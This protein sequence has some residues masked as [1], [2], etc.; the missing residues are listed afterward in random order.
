MLAELGPLLRPMALTVF[1]VQIQALAVDLAQAEMS[2]QLLV[3]EDL[4]A[5][6]TLMVVLVDQEL[7]AKDLLVDL[8]TITRHLETLLVE[9]VVVV[10]LVVLAETLLIHEVAMLVT[11]KQ[12]L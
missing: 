10:V 7:P 3:A 6:A 2:E 8:E 1:L 4:V 9:L 5:A 12:V 11:V